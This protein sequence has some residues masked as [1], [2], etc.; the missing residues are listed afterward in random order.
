MWSFLCDC[1]IKYFCVHHRNLK[2]FSFMVCFSF[3]HNKS[4]LMTPFFKTCRLFI[5]QNIGL[6]IQGPCIYTPIM[7]CISTCLFIISF[8]FN[9]EFSN[10]CV[11]CKLKLNHGCYA[12]GTHFLDTLAYTLIIIT[13]T[14]E[15]NM[16]YAN[17]TAIKISS[18]K[19]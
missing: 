9:T 11:K 2:Q 14:P 17:Y 19:K 3:P 4:I 12:N 18:L 13:C 8:S 6:Y 10:P 15:T 7:L 5:Y 16:A 1:L